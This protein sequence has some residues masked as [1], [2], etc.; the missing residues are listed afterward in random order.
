MMLVS[1]W[2]ASGRY[3]SPHS[4]PSACI[5]F[6]IANAIGKLVIVAAC[7]DIGVL[8]CAA[9]DSH[10]GVPLFVP[11]TETLTSPPAEAPLT[12]RSCPATLCMRGIDLAMPLKTQDHAIGGSFPNFVLIGSVRIAVLG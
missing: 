12:T 10:R 5:A 1:A 9:L 4:R 2:R 8:L 11:D 6:T 7:C 3:P